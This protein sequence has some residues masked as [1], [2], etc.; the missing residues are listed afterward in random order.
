MVQ[1]Y[2][3]YV[4]TFELA[5]SFSEGYHRRRVRRSVLGWKSLHDS[6]R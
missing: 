4:G 3:K 1:F 2:D 5:N 6:F